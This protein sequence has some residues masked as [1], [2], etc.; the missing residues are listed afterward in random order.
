MAWGTVRLAL[1]WPTVV[2]NVPSTAPP[3]K[4]AKLSAMLLKSMAWL[5]VPVRLLGLLESLRAAP[6][7]A[8]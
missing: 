4:G 8:V 5:S 2:P 1:S 3:V 7:W 6:V